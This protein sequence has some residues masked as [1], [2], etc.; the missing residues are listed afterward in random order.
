MSSEHRTRDLRHS[1]MTLENT[2]VSQ[3]KRS[4]SQRENQTGQNLGLC[5]LAAGTQVTCI[6]ARDQSCAVMMN[7]EF[8]TKVWSRGESIR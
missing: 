2:Q 1:G 4:E 7:N 3:M 8:E 5:E 6:T